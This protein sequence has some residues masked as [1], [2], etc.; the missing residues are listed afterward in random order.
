MMAFSLI[1]F[2]VAIILFSFGFWLKGKED[3]RLEAMTEKDELR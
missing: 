1:M 2:L 3:G